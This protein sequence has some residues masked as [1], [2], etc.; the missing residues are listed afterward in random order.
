MF[1][2]FVTWWG[3]LTTELRRQG[4][5]KW[6]DQM[7]VR[8][9]ARSSTSFSASI[10]RGLVLTGDVSGDIW[11]G[12]SVTAAALDPAWLAPEAIALVD[13]SPVGETRAPGTGF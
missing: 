3:M 4:S 10:R 5:R 1:V 2:M 8:S 7:G 9:L 13:D 11:L 12:S 6:V